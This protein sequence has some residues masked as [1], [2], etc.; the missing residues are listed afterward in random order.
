M[1]SLFYIM[2]RNKI[3]RLYVTISQVRSKSNLKIVMK[4]LKKLND[5]DDYV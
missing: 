2:T 1:V 4:K 5:L 3:N